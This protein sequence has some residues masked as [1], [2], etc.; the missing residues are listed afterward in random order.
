MKQSTQ[1]KILSTITFLLTYFVAFA[2]VKASTTI[3]IDALTKIIGVVF[4][5]GGI[6]M[7]FMQMRMANK[8]AELEARFNESINKVEKSFTNAL[9]IVEDKL[10]IKIALSGKEIEAKMATRHDIDNLKTVIKL[11][12]EISEKTNEALKQQLETAANIYRR[13][14]EA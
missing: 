13:D 9:N 10:E 2:Q 6:F 1:Y 5:I 14:K 11:Q 3:E 4:T 7:G 8:M 12:H